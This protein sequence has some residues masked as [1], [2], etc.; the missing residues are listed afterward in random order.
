MARIASDLRLKS[1]LIREYLEFYELDN[2]LQVLA[3]QSI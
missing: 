3:L 2:T 1:Q